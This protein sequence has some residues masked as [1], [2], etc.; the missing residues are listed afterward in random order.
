MISLI[1]T[2]K[3][4]AQ[5]SILD[6]VTMQILFILFTVILSIKYYKESTLLK[7]YA[8]TL[9]LSSEATL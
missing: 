8:S 4:I 2:T 7:L 1:S 5:T 6:F 3:I 9:F